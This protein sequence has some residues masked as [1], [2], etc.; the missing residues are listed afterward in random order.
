LFK[1]CVL[2]YHVTWGVI[3]PAEVGTVFMSLLNSPFVSSPTSPGTWVCTQGFALARQVLSYLSH[4]SS[5]WAVPCE[6]PLVPDVVLV[7]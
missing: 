3:P 4:T 5:P 6:E 2:F 1:N 7:S